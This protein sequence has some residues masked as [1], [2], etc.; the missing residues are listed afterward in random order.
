MGLV[1]SSLCD[2]S[3]E[4]RL[5]H[6]CQCSDGSKS[7]T[8]DRTDC[9]TCGVGD[10]VSHLPCG[11]EVG[12]TTVGGTTWSPVSSS[13]IMSPSGIRTAKLV[14]GLSGETGSALC[15]G[16]MGSLISRPSFGCITS[17]LEVSSELSVALSGVL[18]FALWESEGC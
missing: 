18:M 10:K 5:H 15:R 2:Y 8:V 3:A 11:S 12:A 9:A 13:S 6:T 1:D 17:I 16:F 14:L 4:N 7:F